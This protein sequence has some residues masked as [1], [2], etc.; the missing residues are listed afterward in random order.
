MEPV[1]PGVGRDLVFPDSKQRP[2]YLI[3]INSHGVHATGPTSAV[4]AG[5]GVIYIGYIGRNSPGRSYLLHPNQSVDGN[6]SSDTVVPDCAK[7]LLRN[8]TRLPILAALPVP[9]ST[10]TFHQLDKLAVNCVVNP[11]TVLL[12]AQNGA[13]LHN[14]ALTRTMRLLLFE[15][16]AIFRRLPEVRGIPNVDIRFSPDRLEDLAVSVASKTSENI[17][18]MLQDVRRGVETEIEYMNGWVVRRGESVGVKA[19]VNY[20]MVTMVKGKQNMISREVEGYMPFE[21]GRN[22][23]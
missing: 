23:S 4:H 12:D 14:H 6:G 3:G 1:G 20:S 19:V 7:Y 16:S 21:G 10:L 11:M 5:H 8:F 18:S 13:I 22:R 9:S 15:I 2:H 17:S